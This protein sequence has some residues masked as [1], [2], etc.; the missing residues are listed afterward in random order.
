MFIFVGNPEMRE[1]RKR[2]T[3]IC[4]LKR[5]ANLLQLLQR[6]KYTNIRATTACYFCIFYIDDPIVIGYNLLWTGGQIYNLKSA[7]ARAC[8][9]RPPNSVSSIVSIIESFHSLRPL[10]SFSD[11]SLVVD[12]DVRK[13]HIDPPFWRRRSFQTGSAR[14]RNVKE[15][16]GIFG[17]ARR[18]KK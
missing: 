17:A 6:Q 13:V 16:R 1:P 8:S 18:L 7:I 14:L 11:P 9:S 10:I 4:W 5:T 12:H 3:E 15:Q 2:M